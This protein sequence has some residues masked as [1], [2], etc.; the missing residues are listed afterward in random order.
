MSG[1]PGSAGPDRRATYRRATAPQSGA[2]APIPR[3]IAMFW[4]DPVPPDDVLALMGSW[5]AQHPTH[6]LHCFDEVS[7]AAFLADR[8]T[9]H[10]CLILDH[11]MPQM[12]GLELVGRLRAAGTAI[13]VLLITGSPSQAIV[14]RAGELGVA[15][16][17]E[18]PPNEDELLSFVEAHR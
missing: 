1:S 7:A 6:E 15:Q 9:K 16:V 18:K 17:L 11:H 13:P 8:V 10:A 2:V 4:D 3:Q 14:S 12:T 5:P